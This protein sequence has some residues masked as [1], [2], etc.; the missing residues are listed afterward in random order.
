M[1]K[2]KK[3][4]KTARGFLLFKLKKIKAAVDPSDFKGGTSSRRPSKWHSDGTVGG[5]EGV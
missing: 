2:K 3:K 4:I 1:Q 5:E